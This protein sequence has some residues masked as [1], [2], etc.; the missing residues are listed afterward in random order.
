[1]DLCYIYFVWT[2]TELG[3]I[4]NSTRFSGFRPVIQR[5]LL[6]H[7][8]DNKNENCAL[9]KL[10][11]NLNTLNPNTQKHLLE[12]DPAKFFNKPGVLTKLDLTK[13]PRTSL[14]TILKL[15]ISHFGS[16][17][18]INSV[19]TKVKEEL[20]KRVQTEIESKKK[21]I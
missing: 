1:M 9:D 19:V 14:E 7:Y 15:D 10:L 12:M 17:A 5:A 18:T 8:D 21:H 13:L 20:E 6:S 11:S 16:K 3:N 2:Q 4:I